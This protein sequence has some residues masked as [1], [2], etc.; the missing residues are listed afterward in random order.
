MRDVASEAPRGLNI[1]AL[2]DSGPED[3]PGLR[4]QAQLSTAYNT[5]LRASELCGLAIEHL[6]EAIDPEP[7]QRRRDLGVGSGGRDY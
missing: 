3:L 6:A 7:A 2:L 1:L 4:D 5:E